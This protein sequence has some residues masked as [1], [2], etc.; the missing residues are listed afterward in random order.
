MSVVRKR[1]EMEMTDY[2]STIAKR[3]ETAIEE[4]EQRPDQ[5]E[6]SLSFLREVLGVLKK[7][8]PKYPIRKQG[9]RGWF[10]Y[11]RAEV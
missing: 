7:Q 10:F 5:R 1:G 8:E 6:V 4:V 11:R 3:L 2:I 9:R